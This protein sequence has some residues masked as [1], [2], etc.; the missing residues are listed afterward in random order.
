MKVV[1]SNP[2]LAANTWSHLFDEVFH[3]GLN[4]LSLKNDWG[5]TMPSVNI[6]ENNDSFKLELAAPGLEKNDFKITLEN[7]QLDISVAK[8]KSSEDSEEGKWYR[9]EFNYTS[10]RRTF[11]VQ[12]DIDADNIKAE[13]NNGILTLTLPKKEEAKAKAPK[14]IS[15]H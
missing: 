6:T 2:F 8:E 4:D 10:F 13:Y 3:R 11:Q 9:K 1:K 12:D 15:I 14:T 7:G 5:T